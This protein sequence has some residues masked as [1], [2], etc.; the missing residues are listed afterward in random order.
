LFLVVFS[1]Y[2]RY[3]ECL[4]TIWT[5]RQIRCGESV[6]ERCSAGSCKHLAGELEGQA[7]DLDGEIK[8]EMTG[9]EENSGCYC[10]YIILYNIIYIYFIRNIIFNYIYILY[11]E[12]PGLD[13]KMKMIR[14]GCEPKVS[15]R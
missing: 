15:W 8:A 1:C 13:D 5:S 7:L 2:N 12:T 14:K 10:S 9:S 4:G 3:F 11:Q 6:Q